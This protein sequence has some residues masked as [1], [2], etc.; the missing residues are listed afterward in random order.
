MV[1]HARIQ[2]ALFI[3]ILAVLF[4]FEIY[5]LTVFLPMN[6][7]HSINEQI[8]VPFDRESYEQSKVTHPNLEEEIDQV[9]RENP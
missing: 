5:M 6:W 1:R 7:Q 2:K 9:L 8:V 3:P 4:L